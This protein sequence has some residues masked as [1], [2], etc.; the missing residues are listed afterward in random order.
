MFASG[1]TFALGDLGAFHLPNP[2]EKNISAE[3]W[4]MCLNALSSQEDAPPD[5]VVEL[6]RRRAA[7]RADKNWT[8]S[9]KLREEID[10]RGWT[11]QDAQDGSRLV[12]N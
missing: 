4:D 8:E 11:V 12:K 2:L 1:S 3:V 6:V 5:E 10:A 9:D 7:A